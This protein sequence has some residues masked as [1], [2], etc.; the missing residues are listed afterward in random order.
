[1]APNVGRWAVP[2]C[3]PRIVFDMVSIVIH[4]SNRVAFVTSCSLDTIASEWHFPHTASPDRR[5]TSLLSFHNQSAPVIVIWLP[6][7][8]DVDR[9]NASNSA[10]LVTVGK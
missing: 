3:E 10:V 1:M 7:P 9:P 5:C 4:P 6:F 2:Q 8:L